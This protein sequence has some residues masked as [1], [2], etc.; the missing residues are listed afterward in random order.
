MTEKRAV[1]GDWKTNEMPKRHI[2]VP[3]HMELT[4]EQFDA[5][6]RGHVPT[7]MEDRWF[8]YMEDDVLYIHRSWSGNCIFK[9][10]LNPSGDHTAVIN[11]DPEQFGSE[12]T[13]RD[14]EDLMSLIRMFCSEYEHP[15]MQWTY[16]GRRTGNR[17]RTHI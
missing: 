2:E 11:R 3:F 13:D 17:G 1:R 8:S 6:S 5:L 7:E 15:R 16:L 4:P 9:V 14:L 10:R 12:D